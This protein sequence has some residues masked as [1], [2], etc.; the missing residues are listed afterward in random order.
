MSVLLKNIIRFI[1][2]IFIQSFFLDKVPL[3]HQYV[4]P[5]LYFLFILWLPFDISKNWLLIIAFIFGITMDYFSFSQSVGMYAAACVFIAFLRPY[6][7]NALLPQEKVEIT[8]YE[9]SIRSMGFQQYVIYLL[10][11]T[12]AH[13]FVVVLIEWMRFGD[14]IYFIGKVTFSTVL[15]LILILITEALAFRK[16]RIKTSGE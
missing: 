8:Y 12:F 3:L 4:K 7:L 9:P 2:F 11:L 14:F 6:I 15:S 10:I 13:H 1:L 16:G 5:W